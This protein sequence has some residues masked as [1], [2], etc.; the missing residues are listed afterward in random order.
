MVVEK[1]TVMSKGFGQT[2]EQWRSVKA[3]LQVE[4]TG[5]NELRATTWLRLFQTSRTTKLTWVEKYHKISNNESISYDSRCTCAEQHT[6]STELEIIS[7][8]S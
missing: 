8:R 7:H 5:E 3:A 6:G 1:T 4:T 2:I